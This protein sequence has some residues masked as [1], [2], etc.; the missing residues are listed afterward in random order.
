MST[1]DVSLDVIPALSVPDESGSVKIDTSLSPDVVVSSD[2]AKAVVDGYWV[3]DG[4]WVMAP[5]DHEASV[6]YVGFFRAE[7][8]CVVPAT[9]Y[10]EKG[11]HV[12]LIRDGQPVDEL[13]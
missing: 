7:P 1:D 5:T 8:A 10:P 12:Y 4:K 3:C 13:A 6:I 9:S 11:E 2:D